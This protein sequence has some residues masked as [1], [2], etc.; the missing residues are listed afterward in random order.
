MKKA[1]LMGLMFGGGLFLSL[2]ISGGAMADAGASADDAT[3]INTMCPVSKEAIAVSAGT[4]EFDGHAIGFCCPSCAKAFMAWDESRRDAFVVAALASSKAP[5]PMKRSAPTAQA[6]PAA[7]A[8]GDPYP[9]DTCIVS[10]DKRDA[11]G[12][13]VMKSYDG[14]EV[15]FCSDACVGLF[16]ADR[17][18][19]EKKIDAKIIKMQRM[20]YPLDTCL[21]L[22]A[23][24]GSM[25]DPVELVYQNRLVRFCCA[26]CEP[27][28]RSDPAKY[29]ADL[30]KAIVKQQRKNYPLNTCVV[31]GGELGSMGDPV[32]HIY[33]N[34]LVRFCCA[35]CLPAFEKDPA[36]YMAKVDAAYADAQRATYPLD[37]CVVGGSKL[38]S[39]GNPVEVIAGT[40]LMR[41]CCAGCL[42]K[43]RS[44]PA[45]YLAMLKK[46]RR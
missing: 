43:F 36:S 26:G 6:S 45:S 8:I 24:L 42:P 39:M 17:V 35:G 27:K 18:T 15:R 29:F 37:T 28:F 44:D 12:S 13:M 16:E 34:R 4:I 41:F 20:H 2:M 30:D 23:K 5:A 22:G 33:G 9:L 46:R 19:F 3:P 25:G 32:E 38:G 7:A 40:T 1:T 21:V 31:L 11:K 10:G 14:R